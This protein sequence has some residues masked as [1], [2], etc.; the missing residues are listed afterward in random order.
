MP[1]KVKVKIRKVASKAA[2][3]FSK[4]RNDGIMSNSEEDKTAIDTT[5]PMIPEMPK[6]EVQTP[7]M[8]NLKIS[9]II[10]QSF[11][12]SR[13]ERTGKKELGVA[14]KRAFIKKVGQLSQKA[15][16]M[17]PLFPAHKTFGQRQRDTT[18]VV[19]NVSRTPQRKI[20]L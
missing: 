15:I 5:L 14:Q 12:F 19:V 11:S 17:V 3:I 13:L 2:S 7:S 6:R 10:L 1:N 9:D 20:E 8:K 4:C 16:I 18:A